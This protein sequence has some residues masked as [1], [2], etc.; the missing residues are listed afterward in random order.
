MK[1]RHLAD[2]VVL[3]HFAFL[4][5]VIFGGLLRLW[6]IR[7]HWLH[8][9]AVAWGGY[10]ELSG[11]VCPLTPLENRLRGADQYTG[12]FIE[13]Y[14]VPVIYPSGLNRG[15]QLGLAIGLVIFN[16]IVYWWVAR[17][18]RTGGS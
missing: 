8:L 18:I 12:T 17:R 11:Q 10:I 9:P 5:F 3:A 16:V 1:S 7:A 15:I 14:I 2:L 13:H 6:W 4:V